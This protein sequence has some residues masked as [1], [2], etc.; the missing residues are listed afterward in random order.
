MTPVLTKRWKETREEWLTIMERCE[1]VEEVEEVT[2]Y[3]VPKTW[4]LLTLDPMVKRYECVYS[5]TYTD[6]SFSK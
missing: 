5:A 3:L 4:V 2:A 6:L 1:G